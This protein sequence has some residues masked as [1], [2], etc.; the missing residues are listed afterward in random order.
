MTRKLIKPNLR[1][2]KNGAKKDLKRK[3]PPPYK[4][5]AENYYYIKQMNNRT[6]LIIDLL[7]GEKIFGRIEWYD[8]KCLKF[9][10]T[11]GS[12][13]ILFKQQIK[14]IAKDPAFA[15]EKADAEKTED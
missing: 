12:N 13:M 9:R 6:A 4:T 5:H 3:P 14:Y 11:D 10:K 2:I 1:E 7:D 8:E 15:D